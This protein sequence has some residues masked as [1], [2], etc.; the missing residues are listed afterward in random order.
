MTL[1][2][3]NS[4]EQFAERVTRTSLLDTILELASQHIFSEPYNSDIS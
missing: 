2:V 1:P 4:A 3:F